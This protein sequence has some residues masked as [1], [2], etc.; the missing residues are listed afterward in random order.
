DAAVVGK[1]DARGALHDARVDALDHGPQ[2]VRMDGADDAVPRLEY[3]LPRNLDARRAAVLHDDAAHVRL[4]NDFAATVL[5]RS[6]ER[7]GELARAADRAA[8]AV[9]LHEPGEHCD[10]D[11]RSLLVG[12]REVL[13]D[14]SAEVRPYTVVLEQI[15]DHLRGALLHERHEL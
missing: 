12:T 4:R 6:H 5:D 9:S 13:A 3:P 2:V 14:Q 1:G 10:A 7:G 8:E 11:R 15:A